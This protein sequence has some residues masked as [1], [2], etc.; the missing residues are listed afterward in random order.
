MR[1]VSVYIVLYES[2]KHSF[3]V[4]F[5]IFYDSSKIYYPRKVYQNYTTVTAAA[6]S[7]GGCKA[8]RHMTRRLLTR[9]G[10]G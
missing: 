3:Y 10:K 9:R 4:F 2:K 7:L 5:L 6:L 1:V 8:T